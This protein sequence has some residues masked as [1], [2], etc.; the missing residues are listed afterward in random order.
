MTPVTTFAGRE[1]AL[2]GLGGSGLATAQ[3]LV[4][5]G[6]QVIAWDDDEAAASG[7]DRRR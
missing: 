4:A 3:A 7:R 6:A 5:G 1:V 2:F